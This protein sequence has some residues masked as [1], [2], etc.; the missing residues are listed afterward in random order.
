MSKTV[1]MYTVC[2]ILFVLSS[3]I[4]TATVVILVTI[5]HQIPALVFNSMCKY[6]KLSQI[7]CIL[8]CHTHI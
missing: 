5:S 1:K 6:Y 7:H 2:K 4:S 8:V 3:I